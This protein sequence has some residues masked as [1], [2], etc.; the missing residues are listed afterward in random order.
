LPEKK[1]NH[2]GCYFLFLYFFAIDPNLFFFDK[3]KKTLYYNKLYKE[4]VFIIFIEQKFRIISI[5]LKLKYQH[6]G[7]IVCDTAIP[8]P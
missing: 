8:S 7:L 1:I 3:T 6:L 5:K 4:F 2:I